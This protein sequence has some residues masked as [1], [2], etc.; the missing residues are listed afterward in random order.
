MG[1]AIRITARPTAVP[2]PAMIKASAAPP[3]PIPALWSSVWVTP[4]TQR[5]H[6]WIGVVKQA[7]RPPLAQP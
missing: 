1:F 5:K 4:H 6:V 2:A 3:A 7:L